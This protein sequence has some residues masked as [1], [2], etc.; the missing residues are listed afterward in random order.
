MRYNA[1][2]SIPLYKFIYPMLF[3]GFLAILRSVI[4]IEEIGT[5]MDSNIALLAIIFFSDVF[6]MEKRLNTFE[7]FSLMPQNNKYKTILQR[8]LI[9]SI[10]LLILIMSDFW[11]FFI[12][13]PYKISDM[14]SVMIYLEA[15]FA[16]AS[17]MLFWGVISFTCVNCFNNMWAGVSVTLILW[18]MCSSTLGE[19]LPVYSNIFAYGIRNIADSTDCSWYSGKIIGII[20][21]VLLL[22]FNKKIINKNSILS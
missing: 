22:V 12:H 17:S 18:L 2:I 1:K 15:V 19:Q 5:A 3:V 6:Y 20:L 13:Q 8:I 4:Y 21:S 11:I 16:C 10:Y 9:Y 14:N 7:V